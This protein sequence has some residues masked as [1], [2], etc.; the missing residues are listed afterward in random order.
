MKR[1]LPVLSN[2][3]LPPLYAAW[4]DQLL[5]GPIPHETDATCDD[6]VM[7][8]SEHETDTAEVFFNPQTKCCAYV[9]AL[10]NFLV[11]RVI[12]DDTPAFAAGRATVEARVRAGVGVTPLGVDPPPGFAVLYGQ[13]SATL[14]GR[15]RTL[16]C[17]HYLEEGGRC[18]VWAHRAAICATWYCKHVRGAVGYDFWKAL[19]QLLAA[20][21]QSLAR[22]CVLELD[23]GGAA[24]RRLFPPVGTAARGIDAGVLD[25][26]PDAAAQRARWGHWAGREVDY[27]C[28]CARLVG[29][30]KWPDVLAIGGPELQIYARLVREAYER[31]RATEIPAALKVG[32]FRIMRLGAVNS[33][34]CSYSSYDPI[35]LPQALIEVLPYFDGRPTSHALA[36]IEAE[37]GVKLSRA[38]LRKLIDFEILVLCGSD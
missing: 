5:A 21:E 27:Y 34:V 3:P 1:Q 17:P 35:E 4:M 36:N 24:L 28:A 15:S 29:A 6:C 19:H 11:G 20:A 38:L 14:F 23:P 37:R 7:C 22:W 30:L 33:L 10:P 16:R 18:G 8:A 2:S 13:S 25:G 12:A 26:T 31:H 32:P 9:P